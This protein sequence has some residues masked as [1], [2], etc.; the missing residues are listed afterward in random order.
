MLYVLYIFVIYFVVLYDTKINVCVFVLAKWRKK[1]FY[2]NTDLFSYSI[3]EDCNIYNWLSDRKIN[4]IIIDNCQFY[5]NGGSIIYHIY[6]DWPTTNIEIVDTVFDDNSI[7]I[8][9]II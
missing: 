4:N 5:E 8:I 6:P 7:I 1:Y 9:W 3:V 2:R